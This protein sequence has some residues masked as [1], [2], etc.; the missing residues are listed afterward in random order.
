MRDIFSKFMAATL[1]SC[2]ELA[3]SITIFVLIGV[4]IA[5]VPVIAQLGGFTAT[6]DF[7]GA[8]FIGD[9][10]TSA[11]SVVKGYAYTISVV[12]LILSGLL[13][14]LIKAKIANDPVWLLRFKWGVRFLSLRLIGLFKAC[15]GV[16]AALY[17]LSLG[18]VDV[19]FQVPVRDT[20]GLICVC[21]GMLLMLQEVE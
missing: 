5:S 19:H 14:N 15:L 6:T 9:R 20:L 13:L 18:F 8:E 12:L 17:V 3:K 21:F 4:A 7:I 1:P 16:I 2:Y 10:V 11:I